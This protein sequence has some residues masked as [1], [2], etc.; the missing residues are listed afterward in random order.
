MDWQIQ[1][2]QHFERIGKITNNAPDRRR[3]FLDQRRRRQDPLLLGEVRLFQHVNHE[4]L[5]L[6]AKILLADSSQVLGSPARCA[7]SDR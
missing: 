7:A 5:I 3:Q 2:L 6:T 4:Q 1:T